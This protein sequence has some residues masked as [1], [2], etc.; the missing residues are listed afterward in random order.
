[1]I[2]KLGEWPG[3]ISALE[4]CRETNRSKTISRD[5]QG[6]TAKLSERDFAAKMAVHRGKIWLP[7]T[8]SDIAMYGDRLKGGP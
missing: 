8:P 7:K 4:K 1:M 6:G 3:D 5:G 2:I